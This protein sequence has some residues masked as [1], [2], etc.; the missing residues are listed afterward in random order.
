MVGAFEGAE[1]N[2]WSKYALAQGKSGVR[3]PV[4]V[5]PVERAHR[6]TSLPAASSCRSLP[7]V[8]GQA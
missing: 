4:P 3:A 8:W 5:S 7:A 6:H 1:A 2:T